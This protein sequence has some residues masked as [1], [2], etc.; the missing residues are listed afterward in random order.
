MKLSCR[1][2]PGRRV[3]DWNSL[4]RRLRGSKKWSGRSEENKYPCPERNRSPVTQ[5]G[6]ITGLSWLTWTWWSEN[7]NTTPGSWTQCCSHLVIPPLTEVLQVDKRIKK[8]IMHLCI[9]RRMKEYVTKKLHGA[10]YFFKSL[11]WR[12]KRNLQ[13]L[14]SPQVTQYPTIEPLQSKWLQPFLLDSFQYVP[15]FFFCISGSI[16]SLW[17]FSSICTLTLPHAC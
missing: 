5:L 13:L 14:W 12:L 4:N 17:I 9:D 2:T 3:S 16:P 8:R 11:Y 10:G 7:S 15:H 6:A 1:F